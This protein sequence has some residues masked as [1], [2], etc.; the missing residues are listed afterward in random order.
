MKRLIFSFLAL[1]AF[2]SM[3]AQTDFRHITYQEALAASKAEGK[4]VFIDFYT[5]W[6]G[7]CKAMAKNIFPLPKVGEYMN[8]TFVCIKLD[9]E[10]EGVEQ[11]K[12]YKID[13]YPTM[14]IVDSEG[15]EI[16]R[17][18]GGTNDGDEFIAEMKI[19]NHP[20]L[21]PERMAERYQAGDRSAELVA[22]Y[23]THLYKSAYERRNTDRQLLSLS[24]QMISDYYNSLTDAQRLEEQNFFV[25]SYN[26]VTDPKQPSAQFLINNKDKFDASMKDLVNATLDKLLR[27]RMGM[28]MSGD[29]FVQEDVD[30]LEDAIKKSGIGKKDEFVPTI[31]TLSAK[32]QG[33]E[34]YLATVMKY[35]DKM[36]VSDRTHIASTLGTN[37]TSEDKALCSK[38][39]K[40]LR[41]KLAG[42]HYSE[43]YYVAS[44]LKSLETR[45]NPNIDNE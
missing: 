39:A 42:M 23:A 38:A 16:F 37:I 44:S 7:P 26:F 22:A 5:S 41:S 20:D 33:D 28:L 29:P 35:Y 11:A 3:N 14:V 6:C 36:N 15:K 32:L 10:K 9:A 34:Q 25:Y 12:L 40:W 1:F 2:I 17:K 31:K 18:V 19:G 21:T 45:V 4:P 27:Y 43:L 13:A 8:N 30:V 24:K